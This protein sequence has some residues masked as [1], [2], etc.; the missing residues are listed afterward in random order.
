MNN[1]NLPNG[2]VTID[3]AIK[4]INEDKPTDAKVDIEFMVARLPFM[5]L[6][7]TFNIRLMKTDPEK[8]AIYD[9]EKYVLFESEYQIAMLEHAIVEHYKKVSTNKNFDPTQ[10]TRSLSTAID[11][12]ENPQGN[13]VK[14]KKPMT[15]AGEDIKTHG[16]SKTNGAE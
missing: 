4:L 10:V 6:N 9:G 15:K 3:E 5:R 7:G 11:D 1:N 8:G 2:F 16:V 13:I 12:E 14:Q